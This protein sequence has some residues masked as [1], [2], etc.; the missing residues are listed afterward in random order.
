LCSADSPIF[1]N[2]FEMERATVT[3][4]RSDYRSEWF[5]FEDVAYLNAAAIGVLPRVSIRAVQQ[6]LEWNKFP[7]KL[8][9]SAHFAVPN[10]VRALIAKL[11]AAE[12]DEIA[13]TTGTSGGLQAIA[14]GIEWRKG[15]EILIAR[16]EFPA[17]FTTWLP[18]E[19]AA[20]VKVTV[21]APRGRFLTA[22]DYIERIG[23]QTRLVSA[24]LVRFDDA[25]RLDARRVADACHAAN[26]FLALDAAQCA[27][28]MPIDVA[29]LGC[30][31]LAASGYKWLLAP[32]GTGFL[33]VRAALNEQ[34]REAPFYWQ[35]L[36][37]AEQFHA[38]SLGKYSR[39]K[40]ARRWDSSETAS[41]L[42]LSA[43]EA[44][45]E[46]LNRIGVSTV[47]N[48]NRALLSEMIRRLPS[49][50]CVLASPADPGARG[51][52]ACIASRRPEGTAALFEKLQKAGVVVALRE[53]AIR[54]APHLYN[55]ERDIDKLLTVLAV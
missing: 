47:W 32:Y 52:Y 37:D 44:S 5:E 41:F 49:D 3:E 6:A 12:A 4:A 45:L 53:G 9:D 18:L 24:S 14:G 54:V 25:A 22:D 23:P 30:D 11:I 51:P 33:W 40:G 20:G 26:A 7:Y 8:P 42:N 28:A 16:G 13:L 38:L 19:R 55:S 29:A 48:H 50:R 2:I 15:D 39:A 46:F 43:M 10:R 34:M 21:V 36:E 35:A 27:G 17:H 1:A 31:F